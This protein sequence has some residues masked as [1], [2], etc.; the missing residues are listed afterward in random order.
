[1]FF[2]LILLGQYR[3]V[4]CERLKGVGSELVNILNEK[5]IEKMVEFRNRLK[6]NLFIMGGK[7]I[8]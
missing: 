1:M 4:V 7:A 6:N 8:D 5:R 3:I 2:L